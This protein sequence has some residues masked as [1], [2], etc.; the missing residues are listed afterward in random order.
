[1]GSRQEQQWLRAPICDYLGAL[2]KGSLP[3]CCSAGAVYSCLFSSSA[4]ECTPPSPAISLVLVFRSGRVPAVRPQG[5]AKATSCSTDFLCWAHSVRSV[6]SVRLTACTPVSSFSLCPPGPVW[7][8]WFI[9]VR[10]LVAVSL[11]FFVV[12]CHSAYV[13]WASA[14][15]D[16]NIVCLWSI[17][18]FICDVCGLLQELILVIL[19]SCQ[20]KKLK[21]F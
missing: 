8:F 4:R 21:V 12:G 19:L 9:S 15:F 7:V 5:H 1:M 3:L 2:A 16:L 20:I 17:L 13:S 10:L 18:I 6:H 11:F 14:P